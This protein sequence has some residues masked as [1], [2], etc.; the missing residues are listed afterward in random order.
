MKQQRLL[1]IIAAM[2]LRATVHMQGPDV[3]AHYIYRYNV[4]KR[5]ESTEQSDTG[6][7]MN[8]GVFVNVCIPCNMKDDLIYWRD[9]ILS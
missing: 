5:S 7:A 6:S 9:K 8:R 1:Q 4:R 3:I 2:T